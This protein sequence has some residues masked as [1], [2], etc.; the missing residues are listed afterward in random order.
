MVKVSAVVREEVRGRRGRD[1]RDVSIVSAM[2]IE[3][4]DGRE[5]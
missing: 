5:G 3:K 1:E 4:S 2:G